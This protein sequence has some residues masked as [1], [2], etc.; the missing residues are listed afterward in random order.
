MYSNPVLNFWFH[1]YD[2]NSNNGINQGTFSVDVSMDNGLN[3][4]DDIWFVSG[5]NGNQW[6]EASIDL[7]SYISTDLLIRLRVITGDSY[8]S[9]VA[10]DKLSILGGPVTPDGDFLS[11]VAG[12]GLHI[13]EYSIQGCSDFVNITINEI[14]AGVDLVACPQQ[15]PF[16]LTGLPS[17]GMWNGLNITNNLL[18]TFDPSINL[19]SNLIVYSFNGCNDTIDVTVVDTELQ[20]DSLS[21]CLNSGLQQ[22]NLTNVPRTPWNGNW[23]GQELQILFSWGI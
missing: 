6:L 4:I 19:G 5:N 13:L 11:D 3:W 18:G 12:D 7:S 22:L 10:V 9:D 20:I 16:N 8:Q 2:G 15:M 14:D 21:F 23:S 1:M 17:G